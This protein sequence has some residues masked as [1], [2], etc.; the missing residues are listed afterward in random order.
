MNSED[1]TDS[2]LAISCGLGAMPGELHVPGGAHG[3]VVLAYAGCQVPEEQQRLRRLLAAA[4]VATLLLGLMTA[5]EAE[6]DRRAGLLRFDQ[7]L[8]GGRMVAALDWAGREAA[9]APLTLGIHASGAAVPAALIGGARRPDRVHAI[10]LSGGRP[11][12]AAGV[13]GRVRAP[14]LL[15]GP[16]DAPRQAR[17]TAEV[18]RM[19][20]PQA[21]IR[22]TEAGD[23]ASGVATDWFV[24]HLS[25]PPGGR[26]RPEAA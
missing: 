12:L 5:E 11:E 13:L 8:L 16:V 23:A 20:P 10:A 2:H 15:C 21:R 18:L 4:G 3:L 7:G 6:G 1:L 9:T 25:R 14:L 26:H 22:L 24:H 17:S 19:L